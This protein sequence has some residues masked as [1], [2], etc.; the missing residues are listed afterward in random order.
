MLKTEL[1]NDTVS[2]KGDSKEIKANNIFISA[3]KSALLPPLVCISNTAAV[4]G[5]IVFENIKGFGKD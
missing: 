1:K 5:K 2:F 3:K 4:T